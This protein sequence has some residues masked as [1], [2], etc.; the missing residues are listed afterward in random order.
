MGLVFSFQKRL[1]NFDLDLD[2][3]CPNGRVMAVVGPSGS[4]KTTLIR[5]LAGLERPD[6]GRV[7]LDGIAWFDSKQRVFMRPQV[8]KVGY[9]FQEYTL[10]PH[11]SLLDNARFA[12]KDPA[13]AETHLRRF[14]IWHLRNDRPDTLSGG[15]RQRG[16]LAQALARQP[17]VLLL[18]EPFSALDYATREALQGELSAAADRL[19]IPVILVTHDLVEAHRVGHRVLPLQEGRRDPAWLAGWSASC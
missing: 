4:G 12:A 18:D 14:G 10:F 2:L 5:V 16:A 19:E 15:E 8:R 11:L 7:A 9:V 6:H 3:C 13:L 17:A 1:P